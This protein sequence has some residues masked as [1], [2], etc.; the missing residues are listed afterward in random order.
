[1]T[2]KFNV[3]DITAD[4]VVA[5]RALLASK[6]FKFSEIGISASHG[7]SVCDSGGAVHLVSGEISARTT[8]GR[9]D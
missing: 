3:Q 7:G 5:A 2:N 1:M 4:S 6:E 9:R 8:Q